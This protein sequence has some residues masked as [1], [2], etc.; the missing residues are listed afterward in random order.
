MLKV[1]NTFFYYYPVWKNLLSVL[2]EQ[3]HLSPPH[4]SD[5]FYSFLDMWTVSFTKHSGYNY[6][7]FLAMCTIW[8]ARNV[9]I[10]EGKTVP[11]ISLLH[12]ISYSLQL[13]CPTVTRVKNHRVKGLGP[14]LIYPCGFFDGASVNN[15]SGVG[16]CLHLNELQSFEFALGQDLAPTV[17]QN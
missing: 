16:F 12:Q 6:L 4:Q 8:K 1:S 2:L 5:S 13:Y 9:S 17:G 7:P 3:H 10:F 11:V 15:T 14:T